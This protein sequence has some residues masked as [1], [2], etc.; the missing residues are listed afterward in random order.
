MTNIRSDL[1][2]VVEDWEDNVKEV[3]MKES[4]PDRVKIVQGNL[5][6]HMLRCFPLITIQLD[7]ST[8]NIVASCYRATG[9]D[10]G[11]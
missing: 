5:G 1:V 7:E 3:F 4:F 6:D 9:K 8:L 2:I 10:S 11:L